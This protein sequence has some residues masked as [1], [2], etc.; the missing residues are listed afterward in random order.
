MLEVL[1]QKF[2]KILK[3]LL[4]TLLWFDLSRIP[5]L[6][7]VIDVNH[8]WTAIVEGLSKGCTLCARY[9]LICCKAGEQVVKSRHE[10][11]RPGCYVV[12]DST[13]VHFSVI[14]P[15]NSCRSA[16]VHGTHKFQPGRLA[17]CSSFPAKLFPLDLK[18][19]QCKSLTVLLGQK[20]PDLNRHT[21]DL[22]SVFAL[23][24][25]KEDD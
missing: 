4:L 22:R 10:N 12:F 3:S 17:Y 6:V 8:L 16:H 15:T 5:E 7:V 24:G 19:T 20:L 1:Y 18:K 21:C 2:G 23:L 11:Y 9:I 13:L 25:R 14:Y